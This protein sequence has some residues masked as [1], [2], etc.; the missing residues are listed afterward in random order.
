MCGPWTIMSTRLP[1]QI[2]VPKKRTWRDLEK[3]HFH[4]IKQKTGSGG[5]GWPVARMKETQLSNI[6]NNNALGD[7]MWR[8]HCA[9]SSMISWWSCP[10]HHMYLYSTGTSVARMEGPGLAKLSGRSLSSWRDSFPER[11]NM[12]PCS[13]CLGNTGN[14]SRH[15]GSSFTEYADIGLDGLVNLF[16]D[17]L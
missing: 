6:Y 14:T 5:G 10:R 15:T 3:W 17:T 16:T 8:R 9:F 7:I 13:V 2:W 12:P 11:K 1:N 4:W